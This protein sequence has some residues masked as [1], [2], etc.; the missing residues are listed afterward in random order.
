MEDRQLAIELRLSRELRDRRQSGLASLPPDE[1]TSEATPI[2]TIAT[3][4]GGNGSSLQPGESH[5]RGAD[6]D[7]RRTRED[8]ERGRPQLVGEPCTSAA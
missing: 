2:A 7:D 3:R 6:L 8:L 4:C 5:P 1:A